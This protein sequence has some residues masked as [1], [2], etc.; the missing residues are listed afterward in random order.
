MMSNIII[1]IEVHP[2]NSLFCGQEC[3][4]L[5]RKEGFKQC[6]IYGDLKK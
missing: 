2:L 5:S 3:P 6:K 4:F 1:Q